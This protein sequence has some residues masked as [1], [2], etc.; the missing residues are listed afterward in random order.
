MQADIRANEVSIPYKGVH[1]SMNA[2]G[3]SASGIA[4]ER[5]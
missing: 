4:L 2:I 1:L 5:L 3:V